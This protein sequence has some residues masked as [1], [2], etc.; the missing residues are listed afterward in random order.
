MAGAAAL[1]SGTVVRISSDGATKGVKLPTGVAGHVVYVL[2]TSGTAANIFAA[3]GG[4][5]NAQSADTGRAI[6]ASKGVICICTAAD[7]WTVFDLTA[8]AGAAA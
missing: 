5:L 4:T 1:G 3:A 8:L 2:N 6:P 7:T